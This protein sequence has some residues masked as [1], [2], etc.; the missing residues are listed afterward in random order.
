MSAVGFCKE[1]SC[2]SG[3]INTYTYTDSEGLML[4]NRNAYSY[5]PYTLQNQ[6]GEKTRLY[7][8]W[9]KALT[10]INKIKQLC[11]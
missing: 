11:K 4:R 7:Y 2:W 10:K 5:L 3:L 1:F 8:L 6:F 9:K